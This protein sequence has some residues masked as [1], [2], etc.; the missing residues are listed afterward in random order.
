[1]LHLIYNNENKMSHLNLT[2]QYYYSN[3]LYL[4]LKY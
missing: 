3:I 4:F 1:M 2:V